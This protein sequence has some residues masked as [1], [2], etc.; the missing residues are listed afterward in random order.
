VSDEVVELLARHGVEWTATDEE[1]LARSLGRGLT[2]DDLYRPYALGS[3][4]HA[5]R[6][7]FRDRQLSDLIGFAYHSWDA[8]AAAADFVERVRGAGRR[9]TN[10][11]G[12]EDAVV[13]VI[14]D[15]EN[16]WE[17][18][19]GGGRPFLRSLYRQLL[20]APDLQTV[21]MSE[22]AAGPARPLGSV[23]PGSW[24][25]GDFYVWAGHKDDHRAWAQLAAAR[26]AVDAQQ[27]DA[28]R[29]ALERAREELFIAEGSDWF[30]WYGDDHSSDHDREFDDLFRRHVRNVYRALGLP[31]PDDLHRSNITTRP[32]LGPVP[33]GLLTSP[34]VDG[35]ARDF[36][37]WAGAV[38]VPLNVVGGTMHRT[39]N[40][41]VRGLRVA[42][43]QR[44]LY[45]RFDGAE[46]VRRFLATD[47]EIV[48]L[49]H[50][51]RAQ[52]LELRG[53][54][55]GDDEGPRWRAEEVVTA[56][57]PFRALGARAGE[58]VSATI[59][60][61]DQA[62]HVLEQ[63]PAAEPL[64]VFVPTAGHDAERWVV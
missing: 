15:G 33:L 31:V 60:V 18:Y 27:H 10:A 21:T 5:V 36:T 19:P 40:Q 22:A 6:G 56:A 49:Q 7:L 61:T 44:H 51:P 57:V 9:Y 38:E 55:D 63:Y 17:H 4:G 1:I 25:A 29:E 16:A 2:A 48:V 41:L 32:P 30:W 45:F 39:A 43:D 46:L 47:L 3:G 42:A 8:A 59:L 14:L 64:I 34:A 28:P 26:A 50:Q 12:G 24:I 54:R 35:Q 20:D 23:F 11:G 58:V 13:T 52:R 53:P 37:Q 62:G